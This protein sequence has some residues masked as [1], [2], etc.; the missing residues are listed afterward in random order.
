MDVDQQIQDLQAQFQ[1]QAQALA[2]LQQ[3]A[4][5]VL[6]PVIPAPVATPFAL[7]PAT[8]NQDDIDLTS[9]TGIKLYKTITLPLETKFDGSPG[10]LLSFMDNLHQ[11][12]SCFGWN[13]ELLAISNQHPAN[14]QQR[15][16]LTNH[17]MLMMENVQV[18]AA[19]Y[20]GTQTRQ[21]QNASMMYEFLR[22]SMTEGV[23]TRMSTDATKYTVQGTEDGP[24]YL[25]AIL[26][27]IYVETKATNYHLRQKIHRLSKTMVDLNHNVADFNNH[28]ME[29]VQDFASGGET[30]DD[31]IVYVFE[32][33]L[34]VTDNTFNWYIERKKET[35]DDGMEDIT[36][37]A[38]MDMGFT[39][40]NQLK[41]SDK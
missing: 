26:I 12:A 31:L 32:A 23:C 5:Q 13:Q 33:Y 30:L 8:A 28:V 40:Y 29:I 38:L 9:A 17:H 36:A 41:Q 34:Q 1:Q 25:K 7:T 37:D 14:P 20:I 18:H 6:P 35:Y 4:A 16:L 3:Q 22:D 2:L 39:K 21:A 11:K 10:K 15:N 27:T 24:C 19:A